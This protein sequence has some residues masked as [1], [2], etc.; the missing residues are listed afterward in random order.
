LSVV[1]F[2]GYVIANT[3]HAIHIYRVIY[4]CCRKII[5]KY[6]SRRQHGQLINFSGRVNKFSSSG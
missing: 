4:F 2:C 3:L 5:L 6:A 1:K